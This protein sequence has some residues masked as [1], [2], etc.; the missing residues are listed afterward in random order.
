MGSHKIT[1]NLSRAKKQAKYLIIRIYFA[2]LIRKFKNSVIKTK[3]S[4]PESFIYI[5]EPFSV[6]L[7]ELNKHYLI[8]SGWVE[9][10]INNKSFFKGEHWPWLTFPAIDFLETLI[11]EKLNVL[12]FGAGASTLYFAKRSNKVISY[13]FDVEY[14]NSLDF[15]SSNFANTEIRYLEPFGDD[16]QIRNSPQLPEEEASKIQPFILEDEK[17]FGINASYFRRKEIYRQVSSEIANSSLILIDGGPRNTA[18][19]L[20]AKHAKDDT[21]VIVDNSDQGYLVTGLAT[22]AAAGFLKFHLRDF[23]H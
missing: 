4:I 15:V 10:K 22:L 23:A 1:V 3:S 20:V 2:P 14:Y 19:H 9:S 6:G 13:E 18:L 16:N 5:K 11:L 7:F 8:D 17:L 12:E 21:I